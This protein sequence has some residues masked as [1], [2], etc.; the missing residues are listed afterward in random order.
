MRHDRERCFEAGC[1]AFVSKPVDRQSLLEVVAKYA[2]AAEA[3]AGAE[4]SI[5]RE[6]S[7]ADESVELCLVQNGDA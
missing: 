5:D 4:D 2:K 7:S 3:P 6:A 1:D